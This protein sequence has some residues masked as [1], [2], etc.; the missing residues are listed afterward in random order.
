MGW[1]YIALVFGRTRMKF[2]ATPEN[3]TLNDGSGTP[4][5]IPLDQWIDLEPDFE[6]DPSATFEQWS[7]ELH[8]KVVDGNQQAANLPSRA[9]YF[10]KIEN[11]RASLGVE[12]ESEPTSSPNLP[13]PAEALAELAKSPVFE[14]TVTYAA[15]NS[16][17]NV[18]YQNVALILLARPFDSGNFTNAV[19]RLRQA[20]ALNSTPFSATHEEWIATWSEQHRLGLPVPEEVE[21]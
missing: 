5:T 13:R 4:L 18:G 7:P 21:P 6:H 15:Q 1:L 8:Y 10:E 12:A 2:V 3:V 16:L 14:F 9:S 17:V 19:A 20:L 11:Y